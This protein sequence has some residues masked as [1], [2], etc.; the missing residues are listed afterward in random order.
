MLKRIFAAML[1]A[2]MSLS[3]MEE[4]L[5]IEKE[6]EK[7]REQLENFWQTDRA[8][9]DLKIS[10]DDSQAQVQQQKLNDFCAGKRQRLENV[11]GEVRRLIRAYSNFDRIAEFDVLLGGIDTVSR[12]ETLLSISLD[13]GC[14]YLM[15]L[16]IR[17]GADVNKANSMTGD[18]P[19]M[20]AARGG[21]PHEITGL[22]LN[23]G[24]RISDLNGEGLSAISLA[25]RRYCSLKWPH[26]GSRTNENVV[27]NQRKI[28]ELMTYNYA[29][30]HNAVQ[31][32]QRSQTLQAALD[33]LIAHNHLSYQSSLKI[34]FDFW[35]VLASQPCDIGELEEELL[36]TLRVR[37]NKGRRAK[38]RAL[39][40]LQKKKN[41]F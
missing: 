17:A 34:K 36:Y 20:I 13:Y 18:T 40:V 16:A 7:H 14:Y 1:C 23:E 29:R 22:L 6:R 37:G 19:L 28:I 24:A 21:A 9:S 5:L 38:T 33:L 11:R 4:L 41:R 12:G 8:L 15:Q 25:L 31:R 27:N 2:C 26:D 32:K 3:A 10:V 35:D 39:G 30:E